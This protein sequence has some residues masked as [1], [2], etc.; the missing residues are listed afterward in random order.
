MRDKLTRVDEITNKRFTFVFDPD[1][2]P[3][4]FYEQ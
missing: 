3:I 4:E 2:L 1:H